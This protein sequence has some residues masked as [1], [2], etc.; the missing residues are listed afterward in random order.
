MKRILLKSTIEN[1]E[2]TLTKHQIIESHERLRELLEESLITLDK[3]FCR[4]PSFRSEP[5][6]EVFEARLFVHKTRKELI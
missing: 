5:T 2:H 3:V 4:V 1:W 6:D